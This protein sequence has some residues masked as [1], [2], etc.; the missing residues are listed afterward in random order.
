MNKKILIVGLCFLVC[1][2]CISIS[3]MYEENLEVKDVDFGYKTENKQLKTID[4]ISMMYETDA[5]SGIY[6]L[7]DSSSWNADG[8][9][10]NE[11]LSKCENGGTLIWDATSK[12]VKL[13]T[14]MS[15]KCYVYFD[16][17]KSNTL[18][19]YIISTYGT[20]E[21]LLLH[22]S[23]LEN[24][25]NDGAYRFVGADPNN[26]VCFGSTVSTCPDENLYRI[27]GV[28]GDQVKL[29]KATKATTSL[30]GDSALHYADYS[31]C[32][33]GSC[34]NSSNDWSKSTLN[35][36]ALNDVYLANIG[37]VWSEK[38]AITKWQVGGLTY[39]N[40]SASNAKT[41]YDYELGVNKVDKTY[42]AKVGLFYLSDYYYGA[43][44]KY[45]MLK[46]MSSYSTP[47]EDYRAAAADNW[48]YISDVMQWFIT[49]VTD[50]DVFST[51]K[52]GRVG[53]IYNTCYEDG[54]AC[55]G[56]RPAFYL[57]EN[58]SLSTGEGTKENPYRIEL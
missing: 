30:L 47:N 49:P 31:F 53:K 7:S 10:F 52:D 2:V 13:V 36:M 55:G 14:N 23:S 22:D 5:G 44:S 4:A 54:N 20:D 50:M 18:A 38:I 39:S 16:V 1:L 40:G 45:W 51:Y 35:T 37:E 57:R 21:S 34:N 58:V 9:V 42:E 28:F 41:V 27:I 6:E 25:A 12:V 8:Y 33:S 32:W 56:V 29:I 11:I 46:G 19:D 43:L 17:K 3:F 24:G 48:L 26:Y 15:D